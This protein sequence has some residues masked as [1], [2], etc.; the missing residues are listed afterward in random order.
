MN[1]TNKQ[2][3]S[4]MEIVAICIGADSPDAQ[5]HARRDPFEELQCCQEDLAAI[6]SIASKLLKEQGVEV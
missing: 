2:I 1:M 3:E 5:D 6:C 4:L